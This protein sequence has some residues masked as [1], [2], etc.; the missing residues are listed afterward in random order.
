MKTNKNR[1]VRS[2]STTA[3]GDGSPQSRGGIARAEKLTAAERR[4]IAELGGQAIRALKTK[5]EWKELARS[6]AAARWKSHAA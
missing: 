3:L 5:A 1:T 6:G 4:A 2:S